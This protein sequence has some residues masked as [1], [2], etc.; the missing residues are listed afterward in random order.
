MASQIIRAAT[1]FNMYDLLNFSKFPKS[2]QKA[3]GSKWNKQF[4]FSLINI[5][6]DLDVSEEQV[7]PT[8]KSFQGCFK[9]Q[10]PKQRRGIWWLIYAKLV[11]R[12]LLRPP[13]RAA[14]L[15][16]QLSRDKER[17]L[18]LWAETKTLPSSG[19]LFYMSDFVC[20]CWPYLSTS[21]LGYFN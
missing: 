6:K 8:R 12:S 5:V 13:S 11:G 20:Y 16:Q 21:F 15:P 3:F 1:D 4:G 17:N 14:C 2:F 19:L 18:R 10:Y 9:K 7:Y